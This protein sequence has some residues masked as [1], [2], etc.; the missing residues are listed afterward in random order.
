MKP[1]ILPP[2]AK[3]LPKEKAPKNP[4]SSPLNWWTITTEGDEE[5]RTTVNLGTYYGHVAGL[6]FRFADKA[7]YGLR[8]EAGEPNGALP[9]TIEPYQATQDEV[10]ISLGIDSGTWDLKDDKRRSFFAKWLGDS[11]KVSMSSKGGSFR[12]ASVWLTLKA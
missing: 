1:I 4:Y 10:A 3:P 6:A 7:F 11:V 5:G 8:F 2:R 9:G 12:Y